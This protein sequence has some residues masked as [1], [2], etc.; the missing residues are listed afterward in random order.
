MTHGRGN[1][2]VWIHPS[3]PMPL[4]K[5][6]QPLLSVHSHPKVNLYFF[7]EKN[8]ANRQRKG[9]KS[10]LCSKRLSTWRLQLTL[11]SGSR[12]IH[13]NGKSAG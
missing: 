9:C 2:S 7:Y 13:L 12:K 10:K 11:L 5:Q 4:S 3:I 8:K 6:H 1:Q